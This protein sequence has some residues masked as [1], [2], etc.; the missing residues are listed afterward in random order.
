MAFDTDFLELLPH[1]LTRNSFV[2]SDGYGK[3][4]YS[5]GVSSYS[6]RVVYK[7]K[8][9]RTLEGTEQVARGYVIVGTTETLNPKDKYTLPDTTTPPVLSINTIPDESGTHHNVIYFG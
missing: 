3:P 5:T 6:A 7:P 4:S 9:I 8:L 2:S 1:T